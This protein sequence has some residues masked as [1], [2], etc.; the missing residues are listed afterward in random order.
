MEPIAIKNIEKTNHI[1]NIKVYENFLIVETSM[2]FLL[3]TKNIMELGYGNWEAERTLIKKFT[4][5]LF[6]ISYKEILFFNNCNEFHLK[7]S[8]LGF[9]INNEDNNKWFKSVLFTIN[10][11]NFKIE[12][13]NHINYIKKC[14]ELFERG[15]IDRKIEIANKLFETF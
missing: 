2:P 15:F 14:S 1:L 12:L 13:E 3:Y 5:E 8:D 9:K 4:K 11:L 10:E 7:L 6:S